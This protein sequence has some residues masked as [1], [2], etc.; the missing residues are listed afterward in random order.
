MGGKPWGAGP[1]G[2]WG[3]EGGKQAGGATLRC[4]LPLP[5]PGCLLVQVTVQSV[6]LRWVGLVDGGGGM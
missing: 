6:V 5:V 4:K 2:A 1:G 3:G